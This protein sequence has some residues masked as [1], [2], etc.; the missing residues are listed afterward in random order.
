MRRRFRIVMWTRNRGIENTAMSAKLQDEEGLFHAARRIA[1]ANARALFLSQACGDDDALA[2]RVRALLEMH[3]QES[4]AFPSPSDQ[5]G[6][7]R[8]AFRTRRRP[9][10]ARTS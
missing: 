4:D 8:S 9:I 3:E 6:G 10:S 5:T 1:D 7:L 2:R